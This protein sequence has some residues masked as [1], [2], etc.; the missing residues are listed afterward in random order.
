M[1]N[2]IENAVMWTVYDAVKRLTVA[3]FF[4]EPDAISHARLLN[5]IVGRVTR[6][7]AERSLRIGGRVV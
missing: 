4:D 1:T 5:T 7:T 2:K 6:F 3:T